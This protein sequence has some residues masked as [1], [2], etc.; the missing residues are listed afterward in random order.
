[1]EINVFSGLKIVLCADIFTF[2]FLIS[3]VLIN[4]KE[5]DE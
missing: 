1:M 2:F 4:G 3:L 5:M